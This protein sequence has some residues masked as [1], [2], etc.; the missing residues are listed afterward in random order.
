MRLRQ[1][2]LRQKKLNDFAA[3]DFRCGKSG[4]LSMKM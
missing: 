4:L 1:A 3:A 2:S